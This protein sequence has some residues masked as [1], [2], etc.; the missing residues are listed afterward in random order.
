[1]K[2]NLVFL[3]QFA[4]LFGFCCYSFLYPL[5]S[6]T[7]SLSRSMECKENYSYS[8]FGRELVNKKDN[9]KKF[10]TKFLENLKGSLETFKVS[11]DL[12]EGIGT[13]NGFY[14]KV[15][16]G[17][18]ENIQTIN[19]STSLDTQEIETKSEEFNSSKTLVENKNTITEKISRKNYLVPITLFSSI[20]DFVEIVS[21]EGDSF[22][23][24]DSSMSEEKKFFTIENHYKSS[25]E[26]TFIKVLKK[27]NQVF[28]IDSNDKET[29]TNKTK[30]TIE[31]STGK[32]K[33][34]K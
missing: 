16:G 21:E 30:K 6:Y 31:V 9:F 2:N 22:L 15:M 8:I 17:N 25:P 13:I 4:G 27:D 20:E 34:L 1:M 29:N 11:Y 19:S 18:L 26:F 28:T 10:P 32:C 7:F 12:N 33:L 5:P 23:T 14:F 3:K 24:E